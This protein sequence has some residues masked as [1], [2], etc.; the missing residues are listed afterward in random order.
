MD[1]FVI[2]WPWVIAMLVTLSTVFVLCIMISQQNLEAIEAQEEASYRELLL[3]QDVI[4]DLNLQLKQVGSNSYIENAA[5]QHYDY[6]MP[7]ELRFEI[8]NPGRLDGYTE[9]EF[10]MR[11]EELLK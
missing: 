1:R 2:R 8:S 7:G 3:A 4:T 5:R 9:E 11:M 10:Q 6:L